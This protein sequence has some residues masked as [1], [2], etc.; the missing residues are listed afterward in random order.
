M[1]EVTHHLIIKSHFMQN[2]DVGICSI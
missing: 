1:G 2:F